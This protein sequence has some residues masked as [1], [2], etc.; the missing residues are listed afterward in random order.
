[1]KKTALSIIIENIM[2]RFYEK[3]LKMKESQPLLLIQ[4]P[5]VEVV[6]DIPSA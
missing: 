1:L 6:I 3:L 5:L 4:A 2:M